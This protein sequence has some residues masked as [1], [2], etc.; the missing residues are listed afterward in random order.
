MDAAIDTAAVM[1]M[2][3]FNFIT[4]TPP[5]LYLA[6]VIKMMLQN[7]R[8]RFQKFQKKCMCLLTILLNTLQQVLES[9]SFINS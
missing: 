7:M 2:S 4:L 1:T 9:A 8:K 3:F 6:F 5:D